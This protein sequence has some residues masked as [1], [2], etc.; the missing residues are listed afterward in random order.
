M[1]NMTY[2]V[3]AMA[4]DPNEPREAVKRIEFAINAETIL[5]AAQIAQQILDNSGL[6]NV[7]IRDIAAP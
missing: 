4:N 6:I 2:R 5:I 3:I 7:S 1:R